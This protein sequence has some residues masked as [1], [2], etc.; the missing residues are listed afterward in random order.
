MANKNKNVIISYFDN[1][2]AATAAANEL[3]SWDKANDDIKL[4]GIGILSWE[5][6]KVKTRLVGKRATGTGAKW[7]V[8]LGVAA[9][10][11]SGGVTVIGGA[12][13]GVAGG[14][15]MGTMFHKHLGLK[16]ADKQSLQQHLQSGG[17][18]VVVM[19]D[20][21]EVEPT[22][23]E[24]MRLGGKA[25]HF[26][27]P[28]ATVAQLEEASAG[29]S[30]T[31]AAVPAEGESAPAASESVIEMVDERVV[32]AESDMPAV[33]DAGSQPEA[34]EAVAAVEAVEVVEPTSAV[35]PEAGVEGAD[36]DL[37][38]QSTA[39]AE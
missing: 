13:V 19:A 29:E 22:K 3:K 18:V 35:T 20:A 8:I 32:V 23:V 4:G 28:E 24:L 31:V 17:A 26:E 16:D 37:T 9:G 25:Q 21:I 30:A 11:L 39:K 6:E 10:V 5:K 1:T 38:G 14:A 15:L 34:V 27:V 36:Q 7:G 2:A 12:L 33:V